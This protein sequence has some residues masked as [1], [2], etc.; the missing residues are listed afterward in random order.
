MEWR[1][2][3]YRVVPESH[4]SRVEQPK[5]SVII[6]DDHGKND[7]FKKNLLSKRR[8]YTKYFERSLSTIDDK[9]RKIAL[10]RDIKERLWEELADRREGVSSQYC[11][12]YCSEE[13]KHRRI[14]PREKKLVA[15]GPLPRVNPREKERLD[16]LTKKSKKYIQRLVE[17]DRKRLTIIK[18]R[19]LQLSL[20]EERRLAVEKEKERVAS[21][22]RGGAMIGFVREGF[23]DLGIQYPPSM[24]QRPSDPDTRPYWERD[25]ERI[26]LSYLEPDPIPEARAR[27]APLRRSNAIRGKGRRVVLP[28]RK[29]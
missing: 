8:T 4:S 19:G 11:G 27:K 1:C 26:A 16:K 15:L 7:K 18:R 12:V 24:V 6:P 23:S 2:V 14:T 17:K 10:A 5:L 25:A 22:A 3:V 29:K 28:S 21:E 20:E 9:L 13:H